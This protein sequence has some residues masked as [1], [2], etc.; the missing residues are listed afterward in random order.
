MLCLSNIAMSNHSTLCINH[1][2]KSMHMPI[3][4]FYRIESLGGR[5]VVSNN[6]VHRVVWKRLSRNLAPHNVLSAARYEY[7]PFLA[8]SRALGKSMS[9]ILL[10]TYE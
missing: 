1:L 6:G 2:I 8:V 9:S 3:L 5:V 10:F 7:V 4:N